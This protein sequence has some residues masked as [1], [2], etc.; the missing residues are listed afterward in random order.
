MTP[1]YDRP[2]RLDE[3]PGSR[4]AARIGARAARTRRRRQ[5]ATRLVP[6][7]LVVATLAGG[8][9]AFVADGK[10]VTLEVDG[11]ERR[12]YT[13]AD[14]V[15]ELLDAGGVD[16]GPYD[17][18]LPAPDTGLHHGDT[19]T[20]RH[21]RPVQLT[22]DGRRRTLWTTARTVDEAL[23][24]LAMP[25]RADVSASR[26]TAIGRNGLAV[27]VL[28]ER[29]VRVVVAGRERTVRTRAATVREA[30]REAGVDPHPE[31]RVSAPLDSVPRNGQRIVVEQVRTRERVRVETVPYPTVTRRDPSRYAGERVVER[32]GREGARRVVYRVR[33]VDGVRKEHQRLSVT[34][35]REPEPQV[36][37]VGTRPRPASVAGAE[38][39]NWSALASCESGGR[40][41]VTDPSGTYGGLYQFDTRTWQGV[42][43]SGRPQDASAEEQTYRAKKLYIQ[44][45]A[46]PWPV[47]G[48][49]LYR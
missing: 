6:Q 2:A 31:D 17:R 25:G 40:P 7:A 47:C 33:T 49:N 29:E 48:R 11:A 41:H 1:S 30:L 10:S 27:E 3:E 14:T 37:R 36:V 39:L 9:T 42:G 34:V 20:V 13:L 43:G 16:T 28:T 24:R 32:P 5:Q 19:V 38:G 22:V 4:A 35:L 18:V 12:V 15:G 23:G 46:A 21:A 45:G 44:R 26:G 8:T